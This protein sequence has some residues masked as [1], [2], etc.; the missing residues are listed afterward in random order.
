MKAQGPEP[1]P[2]AIAGAGG[3]ATGLGQGISR[4]FKRW[5]G[6]AISGVRTTS[7]LRQIAALAA[8][9]LG[10][11]VV[12]TGHGGGAVAQATICARSYTKIF[13]QETGK[14]ECVGNNKS[15]QRDNQQ[16]QKQRQRVL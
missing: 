7:H 4:N 5:P 15:L 14:V 10:G 12:V 11:G 3:D 2:Y 9:A 8:A 13:K 16:I 6:C 1:C